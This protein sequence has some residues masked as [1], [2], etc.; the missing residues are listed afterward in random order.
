[1]TATAVTE[2]VPEV[3]EIEPT[4]ATAKTAE[5]PVVAKKAAAKT[6]APAKPKITVAK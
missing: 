1:M 2:S 5:L 4:L 6:K 3:A